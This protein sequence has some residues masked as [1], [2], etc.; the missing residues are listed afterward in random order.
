MSRKAPSI[1][2]VWGAIYNNRCL[3]TWP[4]V[5][6]MG[7]RPMSGNGE[8]PAAERVPGRGS[9]LIVLDVK[10]RAGWVRATIAIASWVGL[11]TSAG[12]QTPFVA[13]GAKP[14]LALGQPR[15]T[16]QLLT[17]TGTSLG[18]RLNG[19]FLLD[20]G[21]NSVLVFAR[22]T[23]ELTQSGYEV[24]GTYDEQGVSGTQTFDVSALYDVSVRGS[25]GLAVAL[26]DIRV[27]SSNSVEVDSTGLLQ[28]NGIIGM[29]AMAG[30]V[31][32]IDIARG[33]TDFFGFALYTTLG[34]S[35]PPSLGHRYSVPLGALEFPQTPGDV[36]PINV[37][38]P[39]LQATLVDGCS[40]RNT[41]FILD[42]G[43]QV[44]IL[45]TRV[46]LE[47]GLD[48]D[49]DGDFSGESIG[50][51][52]IG[53][54]G[55]NVNAPVIMVPELRLPT[56]EG[57]ELVWRD[58][59]VLV[60][61]IDPQVE[62]VFGM[63]FLGGGGL[64]D[65]TPSSMKKVH[66]DFRNFPDQTGTMI[67]DIVDSLDQAQTPQWPT[68]LGD[69]NF[70]GVL[71]RQDLDLLAQHWERQVPGG[72]I[73][74]DLNADRRVDINDL[75]VLADAWGQQSG[76][77]PPD[78]QEWTSNLRAVPEPSGGLLA[79]LGLV[80]LSWHRRRRAR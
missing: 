77:L 35:V 80:V 75:V 21:A 68:E 40:A 73:C 15:V 17:Q 70:D 55:G 46:A 57:R 29:P 56:S 28:I 76:G 49:G 6:R 22:A 20:T 11:M 9:E 78:W 79:G 53:G 19:T 4:L 7:G 39:T 12:A 71:D 62:A 26:D 14:S 43:A 27:L 54:I 23:Q 41:N 44:S 13:L 67:L 32:S 38:L 5:T 24:E 60:Q 59:Q 48:K 66:L 16:T 34:S 8:L 58:L 61:D 10:R 36:L 1:V 65:P 45:S 30:R 64:L 33:P 50:S 72:P 2:L 51:L 74:G 25:D 52:P 47:L 37:P 63:D 3:S 69:T 42:T 31:A 18:P